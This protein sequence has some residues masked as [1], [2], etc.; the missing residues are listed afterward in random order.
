[1][2]DAAKDDHWM[3]L[4]LF[5]GEIEEKTSY[6][7]ELIQALNRELISQ[8]HKNVFLI[9]QSILLISAQVSMIFHP[10]E[11]HKWR[12][13]SLGLAFVPVKEAIIFLKDRSVRN[14]IAH[15]DERLHAW[16]E[17][18]PSRNIVSKLL[19]PRDAIGGDGITEKDIIH[20]YDPEKRIYVFRGD[21]FDVQMLF[22]SICAINGHAKKIKNHPWWTSEFKSYFLNSP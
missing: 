16:L 15:M 17:E 20:H 22:D 9:L 5:I 21:K 2:S 10:V 8:D 18:S 19:G 3:L 12:G 6:I 13:D 7:I 4:S 11:K 14:H 1:M